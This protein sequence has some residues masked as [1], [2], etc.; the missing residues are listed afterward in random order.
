MRKTLIAL[1]GLILLWGCGRFGKKE[2][3]GKKDLRIVSVSK[4]LTEMLFALGKGHEI[5]AC[6]LTS[7]YPD[8]AKGLTTVGYHRALNPEGIISMRPDLVI[9]S[10]DIG[11]ATLIPQ[12]EKVGLAIKTFGAAN[13]LDSAKLLLKELGVFFGAEA[14]A[15]SIIKKIDADMQQVTAA[16]G[17]IH[18]TPTVMIIHYGQA[19]NNFFVMSGRNGAGDKMIRMAGGKTATYDAKGARQLSAEAVAAANPDIIIATDFGFDKMGG[20]IEGFKTVPGVGLTN[21]A[22]N[23]RIY[24]FEEHD[25]VYFGPRTGENVMK[26]MNLLHPQ[27]HAE[28]K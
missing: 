17:S 18:D 8:S 23:N 25:L 26:L 9:H 21:A 11:P 10:N 20:N 3:D 13:T 16:Q 6:D 2:I 24:R 19:N 7:T 27:T 14:K 5:V 28:A 12:L 22:K 1:A 15:D 4:H